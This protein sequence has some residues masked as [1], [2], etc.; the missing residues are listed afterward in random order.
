MPLFFGRRHSISAGTQPEQDGVVKERAR[1]RSSL[2]DFRN[3]RRGSGLFQ[4]LLRRPSKV[5]A[6]A[7]P[8]PPPEK[9]DIPLVSG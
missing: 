6:S 5:S 8:S 2:P 4:G 1:R 3:V 7:P 9:E